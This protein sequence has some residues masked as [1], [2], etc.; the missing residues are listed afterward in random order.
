M[1]QITEFFDIAFGWDIFPAMSAIPER[2]LESLIAK[3]ESEKLIQLGID[4]GFLNDQLRYRSYESFMQ[5]K[6]YTYH[7]KPIHDCK[8]RELNVI[9]NDI[10]RSL[11]TN[12][13][14]KDCN[15]TQKDYIKDV[16]RTTIFKFFKKNQQYCYF[17]GF[18]SIAERMVTNYRPEDSLCALEKF[19]KLFF[20]DSLCDNTFAKSLFQYQE[21]MQDMLREE[22]GIEV[23]PSWSN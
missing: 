20:R 10:H 9:E 14:T 12:S 18:H 4:S 13:A 19:A 1:S 8:I 11:N 6:F 16:M 23:D 15:W 17:Q 3:H 7:N 21:W 2:H 5:I 22:K